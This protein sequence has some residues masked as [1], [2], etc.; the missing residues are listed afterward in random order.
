MNCT[1]HETAQELRMLADALD[2]IPELSIPAPRVWFYLDDKDTFLAIA[3]A[4]PRPIKKS[5]FR[6]ESN[7]PDIHVEHEAPGL[8]SL[9]V[10]AQSKICTLVAPAQPAKFKCDFVLTAEE[11]AQIGNDIEPAAV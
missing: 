5:V 9:A 11:E 1:A 8:K 7:Y 10:I 4:L 3:R 2:A 6:P